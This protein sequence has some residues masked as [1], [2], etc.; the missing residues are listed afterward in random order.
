VGEGFVKTNIG[1]EYELDEI[2]NKESTPQNAPVLFLT[3]PPYFPSCNDT[4]KG[5]LIEHKNTPI[6]KIKFFN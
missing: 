1:K 6:D 5:L 3:V 2:L 4:N